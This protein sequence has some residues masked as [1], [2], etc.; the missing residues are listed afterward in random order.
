MLTARTPLLTVR[1]RRELPSRSTSYKKSSAV[2]CPRAEKVRM[3]VQLSSVGVRIKLP[4]K[5]AD[6]PC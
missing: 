4:F 1:W 6:I 3:F 5:F 2:P